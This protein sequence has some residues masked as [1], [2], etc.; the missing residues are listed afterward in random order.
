MQSSSVSIQFHNNTTSPV[1]VGLFPSANQS[2][3]ALTA[4]DVK[5]LPY[6]RIRMIAAESGDGVARLFN[7]IGTSKIRGERFLNQD[8][9]ALTTTNP[10]RQWFWNIIAQR[11]DTVTPSSIVLTAIITVTYRCKFTKR[12]QILPS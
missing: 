3:V 10:A 9:G 5:E 12:R 11:A 7:S 6:S 4:V 2:L 1:Y 8:Y